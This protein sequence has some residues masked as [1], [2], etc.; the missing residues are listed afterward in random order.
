MNPGKSGKIIQY[1]KHLHTEWKTS[2]AFDNGIAIILGKVHH[3]RQKEGLYLI[4]IDCD[5]RKAIEEICSR[6]D[7]TISLSQ[8]SQ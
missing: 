5:N 8:L 4:G 1:P 7:Q 3:N 2:G 6:N